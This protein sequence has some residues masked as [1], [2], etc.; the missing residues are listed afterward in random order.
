MQQ[1]SCSHSSPAL[2]RVGSDLG[3]LLR[4]GGAADSF[5][6]PLTK[7]MHICKRQEEIQDALHRELDSLEDDVSL[8]EY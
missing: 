2:Q 1:A 8:Q 7:N 5:G 6:M 3:P 4:K